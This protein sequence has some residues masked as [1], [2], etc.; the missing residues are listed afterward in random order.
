MVACF[1]VTT[2]QPLSDMPND[3]DLER[4]LI[5]LEEWRITVDRMLAGNGNGNGNR[6]VSTWSVL[7]LA[8]IVA[9]VATGLL[10]MLTRI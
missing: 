7:L 5:R 4:R 10:L 3:L 2:S 9:F 8:I 1:A 6:M